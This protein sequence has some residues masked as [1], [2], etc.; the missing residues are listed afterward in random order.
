MNLPVET[1]FTA[2]LGLQAPWEV[3]QVDLDTSKRRIDFEVTCDTKRLACPA[4]GTAEQGIHR[5][6]RDW[7]HLDF[8]SL[9]PGCMPTFRA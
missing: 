7:R 1:L 9:K 2:A 8:S 6:R 5:V 4:C 3:K